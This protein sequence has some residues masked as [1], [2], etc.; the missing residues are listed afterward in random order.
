M[1]EIRAAI[2][3]RYS[4][5]KQTDRSIE[6]QAALCRALCKRD[7]LLVIE[8]YADRALLDHPR[9]LGIFRIGCCGWYAPLRELQL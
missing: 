3:A 6:D 9:F 7:S 5:D 1:T 2:C 4:S 8:L